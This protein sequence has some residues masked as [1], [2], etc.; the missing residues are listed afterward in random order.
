MFAALRYHGNKVV[1]LDNFK[2][3]RL[4]KWFFHT[5]IMVTCIVF[6]FCG[7]IIERFIILMFTTFT[8]IVN[9]ATIIFVVIN[10]C[11]STCAKPGILPNMSLWKMFLSEQ[12]THIQ[13]ILKRTDLR[14]SSA[15]LRTFFDLLPY[16]FFFCLC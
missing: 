1:K 5:I 4:V 7:Y 8:F 16:S 12:E 11:L 6:I 15:S 2:R 13:D 10:I 14:K 3:K 9:Y